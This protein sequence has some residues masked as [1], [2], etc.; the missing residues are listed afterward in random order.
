MD[1]SKLF[2]IAHAV[3]FA[4]AR[5]KYQVYSENFRVRD[6]KDPYLE[7]KLVVLD[8]MATAGHKKLYMT[9]FMELLLRISTVRYPPIPLTVSEVA[10]SLQKLFINHFYKY[11]GILEQFRETV[12][13]EVMQNRV[14]AFTSAINAQKKKASND[15]EKQGGGSGRKANSARRQMNIVEQDEE[16]DSDDEEYEEGEE[17]DAEVAIDSAT[18]AV[19]SPDNAEDKAAVDAADETVGDEGAPAHEVS[20]TRENST[21]PQH[22]EEDKADG[23]EVPR[24]T[25][26]PPG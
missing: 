22:R 1:L 5:E 4:S 11:E 10:K 8:E 23:D 2:E 12:D 6:V 20:E 21:S 13:Q 25:E 9:D 14:E 26:A 15:V 19:G 24:A 7:C 17:G 16:D 18:Q 3:I